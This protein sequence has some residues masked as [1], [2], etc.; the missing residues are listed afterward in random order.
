MGLGGHPAQ[1]EEYNKRIFNKSF[2]VDYEK[3]NDEWGLCK[4]V[5]F[6]TSAKGVNGQEYAPTERTCEIS[7]HHQHLCVFMGGVTISSDRSSCSDDGLLYIRGSSGGS[8]FF[9]F[10]LSPLMQ[11]MLQ[12]SL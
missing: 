10:S 8:N 1:R 11:L 7:H 3:G 12:V 5:F 4:R 9:R 2:L 6:Q